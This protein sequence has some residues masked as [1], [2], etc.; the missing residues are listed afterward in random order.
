MISTIKKTQTYLQEYIFHQQLRQPPIHMFLTQSLCSVLH[1]IPYSNLRDWA[2]HPQIIRCH[3]NK[4]GMW[5]SGVSALTYNP[6][7]VFLHDQWE[8]PAV[9]VGSIFSLSLRCLTGA[10][11]RDLRKIGSIPVTSLWE[12]KH[13]FWDEFLSLLSPDFH[14]SSCN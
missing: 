9:C 7:G 10:A 3:E 12:V 11:L 4:E 2:E 1:S 8:F 13:L 14:F 5:D 6:I